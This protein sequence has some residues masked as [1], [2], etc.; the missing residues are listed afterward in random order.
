M[1]IIFVPGIPPVLCHGEHISYFSSIEGRRKVKGS[2]DINI[3]LL[4][5]G[6]LEVEINDPVRSPVLLSAHCHKILDTEGNLQSIL[7]LRCHFDR[8]ILSSILNSWQSSGRMYLFKNNFLKG[9]KW[10]NVEDDTNLLL[11]SGLPLPILR[12]VPRQ[13]YVVVLVLMTSPA[14]SV[15]RYGEFSNYSVCVLCRP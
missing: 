5:L 2:R 1:V 7:S 12:V 11:L 15:P 4:I 14:I 6:L 9:S 13:E 3:V 8:E 10:G